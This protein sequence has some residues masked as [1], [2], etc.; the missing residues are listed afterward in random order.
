[1]APCPYCSHFNT[2]TAATTTGTRVQA[3]LFLAKKLRMH[4]HVHT[5]ARTTYLREKENFVT[6]LRYAFFLLLFS[7]IK[8][9]SNPAKV[10]ATAPTTLK[11]A[12]TWTV[13]RVLDAPRARG[14]RVA[15]SD[16]LVR[17]TILSADGHRK[18]ARGYAPARSQQSG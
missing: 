2:T 3:G 13:S 9:F 10:A 8:L 16:G 12:A 11:R 17:L 14:C 18:G 6:L 7:Y 1:M 5:Y 15:Q 4:T